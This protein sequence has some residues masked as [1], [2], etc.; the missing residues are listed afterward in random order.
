MVRLGRR[1]A[2][3]LILWAAVCAAEPDQKLEKAAEEFKTITQDMGMRGA[4]LKTSAQKTSVWKRWHGRMSWNLRN[5]KLDATPHEVVQRGGSRN[6]LRRNQFALNVGGPL[7]IPGLY[8]GSGRTFVN[9]SYEGVRERI[10]RSFLTTVAIAPERAGDFS[11]T[12]DQAGNPLPV[13]DPAST[14]LNP[15]FNPNEPVS[16]SNLQYLRDPFPANRIPQTRIDPVAARAVDF[17]PQANADAGPFFRN[18]Y[19][20]FSPEK[21]VADGMLFKV[22]HTL[23]EQHRVT[24]QGSLTDS[25]ALASR[26]FDTIADI[27]SNDRTFEA[28]RG[29]LEWTWSRSASTVNVL[30]LDAQRDQS[31]GNRPGQETAFEEL[32]MRGPLGGS[33]PIFRFGNYMGM[34]RVYPDTRSSHNYYFLTN[35]YATRYG[36]HRLRY[37]GQ[38]RRYQVNSFQPNYPAGFFQFGPSLTS[39]PGINNTGLA[40]ASFLLGL[41]ESGRATVIEHPSYWRAHAIRFN[42]QDQYEL[43]KNLIVTVALGVDLKTPR[44]EKYDRFST[45]DLNAINPENGLPGALRFAGKDGTPRHLQDYRWRPDGSLAVAWNPNG[46]PKSVVRMNYGFSYGRIPV[47]T[48]QWASQ[49]YVARPVYISQNIQLEP[50]VRLRDGAP[51]LER[52]LPDLRPEAAN[53]TNADLVE[54]TSE[55]PFYQSAGLSYERELPGQTIVN[56]SLAHARGQRLF[57]GNQAVNFN[58]IPLDFLEFRDELN[59]EAFRR[60]IRPYPHFQRFDVQSSWPLGNYKRNA[61][62]LRLEKRSSTGL[63]LNTTYEFSKQLD[64]YSGPWGVQ[65]FYNRQNEWSLSASNHPQR[66]S[67]SFS[68]ELPI[69]AK[70]QVLVFQDWRRYFVDGWTLSGITSVQNGTPLALAPQFNNT[71]GVIEALRVNLVPG[72]DPAPE[73]RGPESWFNPA[74]FAQ[75]PDFTPGDGPRT[76]PQLLGPGFQNHDLSVTKRFAV[77]AERV[78]ELSATGFNWTNT[79]NWGPVDTVIGPA[80]APNVNAGRSNESRG[81]RVIQVG[82]RFSF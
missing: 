63:T 60:T 77:T 81:G 28:R 15:N 11:Q 79:G 30:T 68:Y 5:D 22:D 76:H 35:S 25:L 7:A 34:G 24:F 73:Q 49:G 64:D 3:C 44:I 27:G 54:P 72:V 45:V 48:T 33:F 31:I 47:Y 2:A 82:L 9:F 40:W 61:A 12:V 32:G 56:L 6:L 16:L 42:G 62:A 57:V 26:Y 19:F 43:R 37:S 38:Y 78:I 13:F 8:D 67:M 46:N 51:E 75:P 39:L 10:G 53:F 23:A 80:N 14:R 29:L 21:N 58:A 18:N 4:G 66:L 52:P 1:C 65:D 74:A 41:S 36:K 17:Y 20:V 55:A 69:G 71:G 59:S 70:K 50:A